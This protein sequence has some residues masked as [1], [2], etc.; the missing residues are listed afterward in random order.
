MTYKEFEKKYLGKPVDYDGAFGVQCVDIVDAYLNECFG[1]TGVWVTGAREL[2]TQFE[3]YDD[4]VKRFDRIPNTRDLVVRAGDIV[5]WNGGT[6]GHTAIGTGEGDKDYFVSIEQNTLGR[7]EPTQKVK[8]FFASD[9]ANPCLGVLRPKDDKKTLD[10][11]G[12]A[13]GDKGLGVYF[14]KRYLI[15]V[16]GAKIDDND[17]FGAGTEKAVNDLLKSKG[18]T[19]NGIA[20]A[21]FAKL[22][23]K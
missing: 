13:M 11:S 14:L 5:V 23:I 2:Y 22:F 18:Y 12:F 8:H 6:H 3:R 7:N 1:I 17:K 20:G 9:V 10:K 21:N 15:S 4:L 16:F 19:E